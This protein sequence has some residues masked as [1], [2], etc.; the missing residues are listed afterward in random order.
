M[1]KP[2]LALVL[3][4]VVSCGGNDEDQDPGNKASIIGK[5]S[6]EKSEIYKSINQQI[7][8]SYSTDCQKM[9]TYEFT[10]SHL[11]SISY[12]DNNNTC[13]KTDFSTRKY[14]FDKGKGKFWFEGEEKYPYFITKLTASDMVIEDRMQDF[15]GDGTRDVLRRFYKRIN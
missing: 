13:V 8:T 6:V 1:K 14:S 7:L 12:A 3:F 11:I 10:S 9:G 15:D 5:W 4:S 2:L